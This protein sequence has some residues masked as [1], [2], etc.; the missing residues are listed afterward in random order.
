MELRELEQTLETT[1]AV[2]RPSPR[3]VR[4]GLVD[5]YSTIARPF[6]ER[7]LAFTDPDADESVIRRIMLVRLGTLWQDLGSPW[8]RPTM[9][10]LRTF[11][12][13]IERYSCFK[14]EPGIAKIGELLDQLFLS[15][16]VS[17]RLTTTRERMATRHFQVIEG[18]GNATAPLGKLRLIRADDAPK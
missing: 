8:D 18:G 1:L 7:G 3:E 6:I 14:H 4:D 2:T 9:D 16:S 10:D 5:Y 15:A 17:E 11:R 13:R 12:R